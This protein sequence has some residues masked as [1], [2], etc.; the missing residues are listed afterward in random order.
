MEYFLFQFNLNI[1]LYLRVHTE[2]YKRLGIRLQM[3]R[4]N[5]ITLL[6]VINQ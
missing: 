5:V 2:T 4:H 3:S 1:F 6:D